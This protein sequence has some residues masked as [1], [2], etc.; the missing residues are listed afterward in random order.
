MP[1]LVS[2]RK[3]WSSA[4]AMPAVQF[5]G[6]PTSRVLSQSMAPVL[7]PSTSPPVSALA[8]STSPPWPPLLPVSTSFLLAPQ[9]GRPGRSHNLNVFAMVRGMGLWWIGCHLNSIL[10]FSSLVLFYWI[11][12]VEFVAMVPSRCGL[13]S[14]YR[15]MSSPLS[16]S[17]QRQHRISLEVYALVIRLRTISLFLFLARGLRVAA[18]VEGESRSVLVT[19]SL[20]NQES[21]LLSNLLACNR[22]GYWIVADG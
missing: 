22:I 13:Q 15:Y 1:C 6:P 7:A 16:S 8:L 10:G 14:I 5:V 9:P 19:Q 20:T 3:L 4:L 2:G 11:L 21:T 17:R 12:S 18:E